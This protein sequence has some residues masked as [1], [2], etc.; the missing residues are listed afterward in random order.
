MAKPTRKEWLIAFYMFTYFFT[1]VSI[2]W[3]LKPLKKSFFVQFY[4]QG[5]MEIL[6]TLYSASQLELFAKILNLVFAIGCMSLFNF[7]SVH[8]R[9][10]QVTYILSL[11]F[12]ALFIGLSHWIQTPNHVI[13]W[14]FYAAG[15]VFIMLFAAAFFAYINS[16]VSTAGAKLIYSKIGLG[17]VIGGAIGS[18][19]LRGF[20]DKVSV[21]NWMVIC[22]VLVLVLNVL[23]KK[24]NDS[25]EA[26]DSLYFKKKVDVPVMP[27]AA[28]VD[29]PRLAEMPL[30]GA[31]IV[32]RSRYL[33]SIVGIVMI[34][35]IVSTILDFQF[36]SSVTHFLN[37]ADIGRHFSSVYALTN[38]LAVGVQLFLTGFVLTQYGVAAGIM[39]LP[40]LV[41]L[42]SIG[43]VALPML[44]TG[45][46]LSIVDNGFNYSL[47]QSSKEI[48]YVPLQ[49]KD[50][51]LV[52]SFIDIFIQRF[53]KV[54]GIIISLF[55]SMFVK[56]MSGVRLLGVA[57]ILLASF[58]LLFAYRSGRTFAQLEKTDKN[59]P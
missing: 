48:L 21:S 40:V 38:V 27:A 16:C 28:V 2:F 20:I 12:S 45:S 22:C 30:L 9:G 59:C 5:G 54:L 3:I 26:G 13:A 14:T 24:T 4:D 50:V 33:F 53:A 37:G 25:I 11:L 23:V 8:F 29:R 17:G 36:T 35:E 6:G 46:L 1:V 39:L 55:I 57:T 51:Y 34:Y 41:G 42:G 49:S 19:M 10:P 31:R 18:I 47:N 58:W 15:D 7:L 44:W 43:F 32:L 56:D 52:K